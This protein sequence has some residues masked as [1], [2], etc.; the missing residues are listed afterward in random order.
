MFPRGKGGARL[1]SKSAGEAYTGGA[2]TRPDDYMTLALKGGKHARANRDI[3]SE[4]SS[5]Q[6]DDS[7]PCGQNTP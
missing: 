7:D 4:S 6:S 3:T 1:Q 2:A 5:V